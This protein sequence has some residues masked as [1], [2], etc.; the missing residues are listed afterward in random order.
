MLLFGPQGLH[1]VSIE[2][3]FVNADDVMDVLTRALPAHARLMMDNATTHNL[4]FSRI[5]NSFR[6]PPY[7]PDLQPVENVFSAIASGT[8]AKLMM[9]LL[10]EIVNAKAKDIK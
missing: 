7:S 9:A 10:D 5:P 3:G 4:A 2:N 8:G 6:Q 1:D